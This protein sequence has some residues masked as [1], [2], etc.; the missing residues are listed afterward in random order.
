MKTVFNSTK[1]SFLKLEHHQE[2]KNII[3]GELQGRQEDRLARF[4]DAEA[5]ILEKLLDL[6]KPSE[7]TKQSNDLFNIHRTYLKT[8]KSL[9]IY[10]LNQDIKGTLKIYTSLKTCPSCNNAYVLF[11][12]L[13]PNIKLEIYTLNKNLKSEI[14]KKTYE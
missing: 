3:E 9:K 6:T 4:S 14:Y 11:N 12:A 8:F 7:S 13:R 1:N 10:D 2:I 5:K